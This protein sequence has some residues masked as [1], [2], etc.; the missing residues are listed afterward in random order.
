VQRAFTRPR[1]NGWIPMILQRT[2]AAIDQL[3]AARHRAD[4]PIDLYSVGRDLILGITIHAFDLD[5]YVHEALRA[6]ASGF[7]L[8]VTLPDL[9]A[10]VRVVAA[11]E[12]LLAPSITRRLIEDREACPRHRRP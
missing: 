12:A 8:K 7:L 10:A 1:L 9:L 5:E 6:G 4:R 3:L 11:G 2:D